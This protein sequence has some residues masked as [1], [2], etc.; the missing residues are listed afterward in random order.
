VETRCGVMRPYNWGLSALQIDTEA[1]A[2]GKLVIVACQGVFPDGTPFDVPNTTPPPPPLEVSTALKN[3]RIYLG[4]PLYRAG[5]TDLATTAERQVLSRYTLQETQVRDVY[6]PGMSDPAE[7]QV[8]ALQLSLLTDK[9]NTRAFS[10]I[11]VAQVVEK[12]S[13]NTVRLEE[14]FIPTVLHCQVSLR[15]VSF[16]REIRG[17]LKQRGDGL[18]TD[19]ANPTASGVAEISQFLQLQ[20]INRYELLFGHLDRMAGLHPEDV[21]RFLLMLAGELATFTRT[22]RRPPVLPEYRHEDLERS[23]FPLMEALRL[24]FSTGGTRKTL[25]LEIVKRQFGVW[26]AMIAD[27]NL[28]D[29]ASFVLAAKADVAPEVIRQSFPRQTTISTVEKIANLVNTL[30][31]GIELYPMAVAP[32]QIP[33]HV[34]FTY[35]ELNTRH[36]DWKLLETSGGL[37][38]HVG[39]KHEGLELELWAIR[40]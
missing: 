5:T 35:F 15:L 20:V 3:G 2:L 28:L 39:V 32:P 13:D 4:L 6:T 10:L 17:V 29:S 7:L 30:Q 9:D 24:M 25:R 27:K 21:Y 34:G 33:F 19:L 31:P 40:A 38:V 22:E 18:A 1:L 23:F 8:G 26:V 14:K 16:I 12:G 37:A 11:P 36:N